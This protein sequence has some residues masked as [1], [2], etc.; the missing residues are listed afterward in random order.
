MPTPSPADRLLDLARKSGVLSAHQLTRLTEEPDLP[1]D[2]GELAD[3]LVAQG[4]VTPYQ[5]EALLAHHGR[6]LRLGP[7]RVLGKLGQGGMGVVYLAEHPDDRRRVAVK[8]LST[9]E[10]GEPVRVAVERF[11]REARSVA[12]LDHPNVVKLLDAG[13]DG[14]THYLVMEYV[15]GRTLEQ[16][17]AGGKLP[18][19]LAA[20]YVAQAAAGLH[21]AH[22]RG[23]V[24]RDVKPANLMLTPDGTVKVLDLGLARSADP[25]DDVTAMLDPGALLG[26]ADYQAPEQA[27]GGQVDARA[28]VYSLGATLFAL[29]A[30]RPPFEGSTSQKLMQ[31]QMKPA[32]ALTAVDPTLPPGLAAVVARMLAKR[33]ADRYQSMAEVAAALAPWATAPDAAVAGSP[34]GDG[35]AETEVDMVPLAA[36]RVVK[37]D[38]N[39]EAAVG[40][41][42]GFLGRLGQ[43]L[44]GLFRRS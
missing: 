36:A 24:H 12:A 19:G 18:C 11:L 8:V 10:G 3:R 35:S 43:L 26:S 42:A 16:V 15:E 22:E 41:P 25:A 9:G 27:V 4:L 37:R 5:A 44:R 31:H 34:A 29:A 17:A 38:R 20:A 32:P 30:G 21:H 6:G 39:G 2:A 14:G 40:R 7:Y 28:D 13:R 33:P 1:P 23:F